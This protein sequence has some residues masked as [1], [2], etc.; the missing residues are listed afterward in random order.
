MKKL[1]ASTVKKIERLKSELTS[2][3]F[4]LYSLGDDLIEIGK[5]SQGEKLN[6]AAF[7]LDAVI[8]YLDDATP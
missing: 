8:N 6:A 1:R 4:S 5:S 2:I 7:E 3:Q